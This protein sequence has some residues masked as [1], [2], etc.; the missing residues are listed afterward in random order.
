MELRDI[1]IEVSR[2][3]RQVRMT[4]IDEAQRAAGQLNRDANALAAHA[5]ETI[6]D[7]LGRIAKR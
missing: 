2:G 4:R 5:A 7:V 6:G 1:G 3:R